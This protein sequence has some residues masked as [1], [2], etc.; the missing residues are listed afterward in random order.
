M[1]VPTFGFIG[2]GQLGSA[3]LGGWLAARVLDPGRVWVADPQ[4]GPTLAERYGV[5]AA[6]AEAVVASAEVVLLAVKPHHVRSALLG[7][8]FRPGQVVISV[9]AGIP[10]SVIRAACAP[11]E[12]VRTMPN[13]ACQVGAGATLV[14]GGDTAPAAVARAVDLFQAVGHAEVVDR[15]DLFH[16]GTALVGS[17]PAFVFLA[18]EALADGA[19]A[20]GLPRAQA[21][22]LAARVVA[23]A[24]TLAA[25]QGIHPAILKDSVASPGGTTMQGLRALERGGLRAALLEAVL[26]ATARSLELEGA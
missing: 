13:V 22:R 19:V 10:R 3:L 4:S 16:V 14:L 7:L 20:A 24:G 11:A 2:C 25:S 23:G 8:A 12:V 15:E 21:L 26:A 1:D 17:G 18:V 6:S 9:A 5:R